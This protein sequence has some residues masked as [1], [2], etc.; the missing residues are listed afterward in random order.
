MNWVLYEQ[1]LWAN[2]PLPAARRYVL[3][4]IAAMDAEGMPPA[5]AVGY[6]RFA[7]GDPDSPTFTIPGVG[8]EVVA[9]CDCLPADFTAPLWR[10]THKRFEPVPPVRKDEPHTDA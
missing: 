4:Q 10:G 3:V 8:G 6:L 7:A 2:Q 9:W 1:E 5:V